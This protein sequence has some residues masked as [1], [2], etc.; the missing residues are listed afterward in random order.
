[1]TLK[2]LKGAAGRSVNFYGVSLLL[3]YSLELS[4]L[5]K[6]THRQGG[7]YFYGVSHAPIPMGV[8]ERPQI[9]GT[10]TYADTV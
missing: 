3:S 10:P 8:S 9:F 1:M 4:D 6:V 7:A 2:T 5:E